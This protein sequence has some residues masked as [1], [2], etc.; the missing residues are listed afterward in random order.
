MYNT[1]GFSLSSLCSYVIM[2]MGMW[3]QF[4]KL[5]GEGRTIFII[6]K[7]QGNKMSHNH[8]SFVSRVLVSA[9]GKVEI[10]FSRGSCALLRYETNGFASI[11]VV[12]AAHVA[13]PPPLPG[14]LPEVRSPIQCGILTQDGDGS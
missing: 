8:P 11:H 4:K 1:H 14:A 2:G 9:K 10:P 6:R 3:I 12:T 5:M 13:Q 7:P